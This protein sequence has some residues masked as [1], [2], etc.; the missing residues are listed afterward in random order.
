[1]GPNDHRGVALEAHGGHAC[2]SMIKRFAVVGQDLL[3]NFGA[4]G[5]LE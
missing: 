2:G 4:L 1:M 3:E 5:D